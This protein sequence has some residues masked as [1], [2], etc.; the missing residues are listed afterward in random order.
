MSD[1]LKFGI[2]G[3]GRIGR[4]HVS[5]INKLIDGAE[6]IAPQIYILTLQQ[7]NLKLMVLNI[8]IKITKNCSPI[9]M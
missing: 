5:N 3:T 2:V 1:V 9:R 6:I 7:T 8:F 4:M